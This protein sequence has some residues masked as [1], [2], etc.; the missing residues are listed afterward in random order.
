MNIRKKIIISFSATSIVLVG[1]AFLFIYSLFSNY[2]TEEFQQRLKDK[3]TTTLKFLI[4]VQQI[5][6]DLLQTMDRNTINNLY[7]EKTLLFDEQ[8]KLIYSGIDDTKILFSTDILNHLSPENDLIEVKEGEFDVVGIYLKFNNHG[9]YGINKAYDMFGYSK[10]NYL[11]YVLVFSFLGITLFILLITFYISKQISN[12]LNKMANE[13]ENIQIETSDSKI[14]IPKTKD[15]INFLAI[16]FN[17]LMQ[18]LNESFA[19]QKHAV[20]HIS[21]ELKTPIAILVSNFEKME[22]ENDIAVIQKMI[23]NQKEDTKN[24]SDI[25]NALLEISKVDAGNAIIKE[26]I[27]VDELIYD[28]IEELKQL[29]NEYSFSVT[30]SEK[31]SNENTLTINA[32]KKLIK[33]AFINLALNAVLYGEDKKAQIMLNTSQNNLAIEFINHGSTISEKEIPFLFQHFF[34]GENSKGKRGFGLGLVLVSKIINLDEGKIFYTSP[35][36]STNVFCIELAYQ[37]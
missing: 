32:N 5:D 4:E 6:D 29:D 11:K 3:I 30:I 13:I 10:L 19:F 24:L 33:L 15:E 23:K 20:H 22:R 8:K 37:H 14:S 27:R 18:R 1:I 7:Q 16:R 35:N 9:Y 28:V 26:K 12:P 17:E 34:R 25:I 2:R 31:I 36:H 21:H